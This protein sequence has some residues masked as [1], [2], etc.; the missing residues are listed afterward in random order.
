[1]QMTRQRKMLI[2][3]AGLGLGGLM[4]DKFVL[5]P[6]QSASADEYAVDAEEK[7]P[8]A[9]APAAADGHSAGTAQASTTLPSFA[10]LTDR[11]IATSSESTS[12]SF[13]DPFK[14]PDGWIAPQSGLNQPEANNNDT[15]EYEDSRQ[16]LLEQYKLDGT[17]RLVSEQGEEI[18]AVVTG[19]NQSRRL[20]LVG[21]TVEVKLKKSTPDGSPA[22]E[23]YRLKE[24]GAGFVIWESIDSSKRIAEMRTKN[25]L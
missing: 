10:T 15:T 4:L 19:E 11:L 3:V 17:S 14:L 1:M 18:I 13:T 22:V 24:V 20:M 9:A 25:V 8:Q 21:Q 5:A 2:A 7:A 6:P 23:H 16:L 12:S